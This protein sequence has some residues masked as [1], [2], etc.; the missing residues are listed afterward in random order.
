M[1]LENSGAEKLMEIIFLLDRSGSM[2]TIRDD[3]IGGFNSFIESQ[4]GGTMSLYLFD[5]ELTTVYEKVPIEK[6]EKLTTETFVPRGSTALLDALGHVLKMEFA[7]K[8]TVVILTDGEENASHKYTRAHVKDLIDM[9][10]MRDG[11]DFVYLGANVEEGKDLGIV[12]SV[13][14]DTR[15]TTEMFH[16]LSAAMSQASQTGEAV[17]F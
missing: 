1:G 11:W 9:R 16:T 17:I 15:K 5:H 6:V 13:A 4:A 8:R 10:K 14:F 12:T 7:D 3:T 2:A